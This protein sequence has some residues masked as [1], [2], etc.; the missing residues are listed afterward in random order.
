V[1][2]VT[3][4]D[5]I[6]VLKINDVAPKW[7][8]RIL[9]VA[10]LPINRT[11]I[12][13]AYQAGTI[14]EREVEERLRDLRYSPADARMMTKFIVVKGTQQA[15]QSSGGWTRRKIV[16][17]YRDGL[18]RRFDAEQ[19]MSRIDLNA[20]KIRQLL[21]DADLLR[22]AE[23]KRKCLGA[24]RKRMLI[25]DI[26][27]REATTAV[28]ALGVDVLQAEDLVKGWYCEQLSRAK[29]PTVKMLS[30]WTVKGLITVPEFNRRL[31]NLGY[32]DDD[33]QRIIAALTIDEAR[34]R[35]EAA[36][37]AL[38]ERMAFMQKV[39]KDYEKKIKELEK[40]LKELG[41]GDK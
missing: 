35:Q 3:K 29:E 11:D 31:T 28:Q 2:A 37:K 6:N 21:D 22:S 32:L 14:D 12:M 16:T 19:L 20:E 13:A 24:V 18:I 17:A 5:A 23:S 10:N 33:A 39:I 26:D 9:A 36:A 41:G 38:K 25:G 15:I 1:P 27:T 8:E 34:R 40:K 7:Q 4:E 30:D